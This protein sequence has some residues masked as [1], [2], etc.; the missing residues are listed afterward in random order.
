MRRSRTPSVLQSPIVV[1]TVLIVVLGIAVYLSYIAENGLPYVPTYR[2]N[3]QVANA[4]EVPK[5]ADVRIGGARV[6]QVL[7]ITPEP[8]SPTWR[9]PYAQLGLS[10][11]KSLGPLPPD[12]HY[13]IR[14]SSVLGG[15]YVELLPGRS[16]S[17]GIPDGGTLK[18]NAR[19]SL[20]HELPFVD[21][22]TA[23]QA[24]GPRTRQA[25]RGSIAGFGDAVAG[26][27]IQL[28]DI[29]HSLARGLGPL[30]TLLALLADPSN[31]LADLIRG[32]AATTTALAAVAPTINALLANGATT[33]GALQE[34]AL[35]QAIDR[36]PQT[37]SSATNDLNG[38]MPALAETAA[39]ARALRPSA[40]VLPTA[41]SRLDA[42][43][44]GATPVFR[45]VPTLA[46]DLEGAIGAV[47][48]LARDPASRQVF[49]GLGSNDLA[50]FGASG[51]NGLGAILRA[52]A[53]EQF[54]CNI[55][56]LWLRNF[57]AGLTEGDS[58]APWLRTMPL[59]DPNMGQLASSPSPDLHTNYYPIEDRQQCQ[60]G[61]EVYTGK[62]MIGNPPKTSNVVDN[63]APPP[64]VLERARQAGLVAGG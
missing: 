30:Q 4:D 17:G 22:D 43:V 40:A 34:S 53:P 38:S 32:G 46:S 11:Q 51:L 56:G 39:L 41:A 1:G 13:Q 61:N 23:L 7:T 16:Q 62:Q 8:A 12:T 26:R 19:A 42:I 6:G 47:Q 3:V 27:G 21:L 2:V 28:N 63:T 18:L 31:R 49:R 60:A 44:T 48:A 54:A 59:V 35:G 5:N 33:F 55:A 37:E 10:L 14:L 52:V 25:L 58:T 20:N 36:L 9:H 15:K 29:A 57:A 45:R 50:T 64:G 24:F